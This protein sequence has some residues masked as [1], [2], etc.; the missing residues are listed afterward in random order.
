VAMSLN[1]KAHAGQ[2]LARAF[3]HG[4]GELSVP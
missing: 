2:A 4:F 3:Q 1:S